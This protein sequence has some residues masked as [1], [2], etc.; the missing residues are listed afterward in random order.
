MITDNVIPVFDQGRNATLAVVVV[1]WNTPDLIIECLAALRT[2][3]GVDWHLYLV[4]N[5][6]TDNSA[7]ALCRLGSDV[8]FIQSPTNGGWTGGNNLGV[9]RGLHGNHEY[10]FLLNSDA[11]VV[12]DTFSVL[13]SVAHKHPNAVIGPIQL[14]EDGL[15]YNFAKADTVKATGLPEYPPII[16]LDG[17]DALAIS[18]LQPTSYIRG[19]GLFIS[20]RQF[21]IVGLFDDRYYLNFDDTDFCARA[22]KLGMDVMVVK[23][24]R[25]FHATSGTIGGGESPL[26]KYFMTRNALVFAKTHST[27][28]QRLSNWI[29]VARS[30]LS[31]TGK[32]GRLR[33]V[34]ALL[35]GKDPRL[36]AFRR[37]VS[38][39]LTG[40]LGDCPPIIRQ[41]Q[42]LKKG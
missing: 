31:D 28:L 25:L 35:F 3:E 11:K 12:Q 21:E 20:R 14:S 41:L 10:F 22:R 1:N 18:D 16:A 34:A 13:L 29:A 15:F 42:A 33:R 2:T 38:D 40:N 17:P 37:G 8:T 4:D 9:E 32:T 26:N 36:K 39:Y 30:G 7:D 23:K 24:A 5:A 19:S 27:Y 6:S